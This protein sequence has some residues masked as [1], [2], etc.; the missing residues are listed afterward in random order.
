M[1]L[2][3]LEKGMKVKVLTGEFE[4]MEGTVLDFSTKEDTVKVKMYDEELSLSGDAVE[5]VEKRI[6]KNT[7]NTKKIL[8]TILETED[9]VRDVLLEQGEVKPTKQPTEITGISEDMW[10]A[11]SVAK[12]VSHCIKEGEEK[13]ID[14]ISRAILNVYRWN[15]ENEEL[16]DKAKEVFQSL[17]KEGSV[18]SDEEEFEED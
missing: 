11:L 12:L 5:P 9:N 3:E 6:V 14:V 7:T 16:A 10:R 4:N 13:G 15:K 1:F 8:R 18:D 2:E 17:K